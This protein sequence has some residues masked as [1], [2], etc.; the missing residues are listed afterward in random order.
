M[1][2][3]VR[4]NNPSHGR[5]GAEVAGW[6]RCCHAVISRAY[7]FIYIVGK[8]PQINKCVTRWRYGENVQH[9]ML[10][11]SKWLKIKK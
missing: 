10:D 2:F 1:G 8:M 5:D 9:L 6:R 7:L 3:H 11:A 4:N